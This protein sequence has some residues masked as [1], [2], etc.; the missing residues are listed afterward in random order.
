MLAQGHRTAEARHLRDDIHRLLRRLQQ[1]LRIGQALTEQPSPD[2]GAGQIPKAPRKS[3]D[4]D[5]T[6]NKKN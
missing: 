1:A 5:H 4:V 6:L 2:S 3:S